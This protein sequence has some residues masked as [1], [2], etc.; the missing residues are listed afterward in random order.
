[1][2]PG[3]VDEGVDLGHFD[4]PEV[5]ERILDVE[6]RSLRQTHGVDEG[7]EGIPLSVALSHDVQFGLLV[8]HLGLENVAAGGDAQLEVGLRALQL[9]SGEL[10]R[11]QGHLHPLLRPQE[12]EVGVGDRLPHQGLLV[13]ERGPVGVEGGLGPIAL[14]QAPESVEDRPV[15]AQTLS[16]EGLEDG[17][18]LGRSRGRQGALEGLLSVDRQGKWVAVD[19][20]EGDGKELGRGHGL[21]LVRPLRTLPSR[22]EAQ[23]GHE[24]SEGGELVRL[25]VAH[26][27]LQ[28]A[29]GGGAQMGDAQAGLQGDCISRVEDRR[30]GLEQ[31]QSV[32]W[33]HRRSS[34]MSGCRSSLVAARVCPARRATDTTGDVSACYRVP[35]LTRKET[36]RRLRKTSPHGPDLDRI[37]RGGKRRVGRPKPRPGCRA[38]CPA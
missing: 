27:L 34:R 25:G 30:L 13:V 20:E 3:Q 31:L 12:V 29:Q 16:L 1:M 19:V 4:L 35:R 5:A 32:K 15:G 23:V 11:L 33:T 14:G 10:L 26:V 9:L 28:S 18:V 21:V 24:G 37:R 38:A 8:A 36:G 17:L 2:L 7:R 6:T 22:R